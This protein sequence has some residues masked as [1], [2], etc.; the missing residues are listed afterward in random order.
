MLQVVLTRRA[1]G[2]LSDIWNYVARDNIA[3]A[4][5]LT[6]DIHEMFQRLAA[7]PGLGFPQF[8]YR[9]EL[10]CKPVRKHYLVFYE[11]IEHGI[12]VLRVLHAARDWQHLL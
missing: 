10:R 7:S 4:D 6:D 11:P 5:K 2:D 8:Q 3:A 1:D 9:D 12:R